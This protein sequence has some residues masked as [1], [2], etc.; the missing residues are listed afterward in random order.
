MEEIPFNARCA[1]CGNASFELP[2]QLLLEADMTCSAC[3]HHGKLVEFAD[4]MTLD[5]ILHRRGRWR[6]VL[7]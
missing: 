5:A 4:L 7:H 3:G 2:D 6:D 1:R